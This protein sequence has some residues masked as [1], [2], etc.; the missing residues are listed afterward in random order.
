MDN[1][2][3]TIFLLIS[4]FVFISLAYAYR[5]INRSIFL[6]PLVISQL[7][8]AITIYTILKIW[9]KGHMTDEDFIIIM[10]QC[11]V[12][13]ITWLIA[14]YM[15]SKIQI[16]NPDGKDISGSFV[17]KKIDHQIYIFLFFC[18]LLLNSYYLMS[19]W[20][21]YNAG[22][23]RLLYARD[24]RA[25]NI[26][27]SLVTSWYVVLL[28]VF[29][30]SRG[31]LF[32]KIA[33]LIYFIT[34]LVSGSK[35]AVVGSLFAYLFFYFNI[36]NKEGRLNF[37]II[38]LIVVLLFLPTF[39]MYGTGVV[40]K[41]LYRISMSADIYPI[42]FEAG[43][44]K[45]LIGFYDPLSYIFH[46]FTMIFGERGYEYPMGAQILQTMGQEVTGMG[47]NS[48][49][50]VLNLVLFG[51]DITTILIVTLL[52]AILSFLTIIVGYKILTSLIFPLFFRVIIFA[53]SYSAFMVM[54]FD[55]GSYEFNVV[56]MI[57]VI[58]IFL[59]VLFLL[60]LSTKRAIQ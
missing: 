37:K 35:A 16:L 23:Q 34:T 7:T 30:I 40:E 21:T 15:I 2:N 9:N 25:F 36:K 49:M 3:N 17:P 27:Q 10:M 5:N 53:F 20:S 14:P 52:F 32:D 41:V 29:S 59:C 54:F 60:K 58:C 26:I 11:C 42:A 57:G 19:F 28:F 46:P 45:R 43:N 8:F 1:I 55:I 12:F 51:N 13:F 50:P 4:F 33:L 18:F 44:Y 48:Q 39:V 31:D 56:Y 38:L 47:P 22:D 6:Q 24:N